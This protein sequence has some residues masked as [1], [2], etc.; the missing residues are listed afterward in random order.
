MAELQPTDVLFIPNR[1]RITHAMLEGPSGKPALHIF[2]GAK[3][4]IFREEEMMPFGNA[5]LKVERFRADEAKGW[6]TAGY[7]WEKVRGLLE[8]LVSEEIL[9]H[10]EDAPP[11]PN[12]QTFPKHL[13]RNVEGRQP[14][15]YDESLCPA[16]TQR[17]LG[18]AMDLGNLEVVLPIHR[19]AHPAVDSDGRQVGE[20]NVIDGLYLDFPTERRLC[21]YAGSRYHAPEPINATALK[22]MT[23]RWPELLSLT[24]QFRTHF[25]KRFPAHEKAPRAGDVHFLAVGMLSAV[26]YVLVRGDNP[27]PNGQLDAGLAASFRLID[28]VRIVTTQLMRDTAGKQS[29]DRVVSGKAIADYAERNFLYMDKYGVCAGP[30]ILIDEYMSVL[31]DGVAAPIQVQPDIHARVGDVDTAI[32]Y[33]LHGIRLEGIVRSYGS[34]QG[35]LHER[36]KD[37]FAGHAPDAALL[38]KLQELAKIPI[39]REHFSFLRNDHSLRET[40]EMEFRVN[41]WLLDE[42]RAALP[43]ADL[44]GTLESMEDLR[45][46]NAD[47][48]AVSGRKLGEFLTAAVP[49]FATLPVPL[50]DEL[51]AVAAECFALDRLVLRTVGNEQE[52]VNRRLGRKQGR[53]LT[54]EDLTAYARRCT[55]VLNKVLAE[56][57]GLSISSTAGATVVA[58]GPHSLTLN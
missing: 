11:P 34:A 25:F 16:M 10:F 40:F 4:I 14:E 44:V 21:N 36:M 33:A 48:Q 7:E 58:H 28:G 35:I 57:L 17:V 52:I 2:Y 5:L 8:A 43:A 12:S 31:L 19:V 41:G 18:R 6:S 24:E 39:D 56:G 37:A 20:N 49:D 42:A 38:P 26:G 54:T 27:V 23:K 32:D 46:F 45:R 29:C 55:P 30:Q 50:R 51:L 9:K 1:R 13:G 22:H 53:A 15:S 3:E 47:A